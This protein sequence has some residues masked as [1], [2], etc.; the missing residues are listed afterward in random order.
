MIP[1]RSA[2]VVHGGD[3]PWRISRDSARTWS[4]TMSSAVLRTLTALTA[5]C[6][7]I[8][9][10]L[11]ADDKESNQPERKKP[12][13]IA[14]FTLSGPITETPTP[15]DP[16]FGS[17]GSESLKS[18][19][20]RMDK[21]VAD[22]NVKAAV[23]MLGDT[24]VGYAQLSEIRGAVD[25][26]KEAGKPVYAH[27]DSV[28]FGS[29]L[30]LSGASRLSI[31]PQ[32]DVWVNGIYGEQVFLR[33]LFD[34]LG[35]KP[36]FL[37]C[38]D[39]KSAGEMFTRS[40]PSPEAAEMTDWLYDGI[41]EAMLKLIASGRDVDVD[42]ARAWVDH[43]L[44]TSREAREKGLIDAV[45]TR[46]EFEAH[47]K[48]EYGEDLKFNKKYGQKS[49]TT[50]D[51]NNPFAV[52][53]LWAQ[54]LA[55]PQTRKSTKDAVA[56]VYID[57][58]IMEG[59]PSRSLFGA[60]G[61]AFSTPLRK[62]L[63]EVAED[64]T[65][66]A[67]VLRVSSPGGSVVASEIILNASRQ[68]AEEKPLVIS[69]GD[70]AGSG[71]Y[72]V[73]CGTD[74]IYAE[75]ATITG[76]IGVIAGKLVTTDMF[77]RFGVNFSPVQRG[78]NAG[79]LSGFKPFTEKEEADL[80]AWM[81]EVYGVFKEHVTKARGDKLKK[82]ID[83]IAGGRVYTGRQALELGLVD[84]IG[85][86]SAAISDA[87]GKAGLEE[88]KYEVRVHPRPKNFLE[89]LFADL[90]PQK[91]EDDKHLSTELLNAAGPA[92][93]TIDPQRMHLLQQALRQ[94]DILQKEGVMLTMP[95]LDITP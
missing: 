28:K 12:A 38:G 85:G 30:L 45:E 23:L 63:H 77:R 31:E 80:Q 18:L 69:M 3:L 75:E 43:G 1:G 32:G 71:G 91:K 9:L 88:G 94:L 11:R 59:S 61:G 57:G 70:V 29:Y 84:K 41:F 89:D 86:L 60:V 82:P 93:Q 13:E 81:D 22:E 46:R 6:L 25:R 40:E 47:L 64:D 33:G 76:S 35:I 90:G 78:E 67:V 79:M 7:L 17:I 2:G 87:A 74:T 73:T 65:I 20:E 39:Y 8:N 51:P 66:K 56:V 14:V 44:Y 27:A 19:V 50:I 52:L 4:L 92:L 5:A 24:S 68:V 42:K 34:M 26:L 49:G 53:Q 15:D 58:P 83:E 36:D 95:V 72:Y 48:S 21:A 62:A 54:I 55:G 16:L 37:T 10:P